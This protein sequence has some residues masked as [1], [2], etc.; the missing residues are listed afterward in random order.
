MEKNQ[1]TVLAVPPEEAFKMIGISR[2]TGY[3][4]IKEGV[5]PSARLGPRR[6]LIP[7]DGLKKLLEQ[8]VAAV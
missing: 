1:N 4:Y 6:L 8:K 5:I 7:I 2:A 3:K